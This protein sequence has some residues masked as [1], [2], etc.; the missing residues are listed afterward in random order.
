M[1]LIKKY[2]NRDYNGRIA[3][4]LLLFS[5][6]NFVL[7]VGKFVIAIFTTPFFV[8]SGIINLCNAVSKLVLYSSMK[9][10]KPDLKKASL[11]ISSVMILAS[12]QYIIYMLRTLIFNTKSM[13]YNLSLGCIIA[14]VGFL[15]LGLAIKAILSEKGKG[16]FY[17]I[18]KTM[19]FFSAITAI[20]LTQVAILSFSDSSDNTFLNAMTGSMVGLV[21]LL[22]WIIM[23]IIP[24]FSPIDNSVIQPVDTFISIEKKYLLKSRIFGNYYLSSEDFNEKPVYRIKKEKANY[25]SG[26][27]IFS[28]IT[29]ILLSEILIFVYILLAGIYYL[30][31]L[32]IVGKAK[33][34]IFSESIGI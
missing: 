24:Y 33:K 16:S 29:V 31:T 25:F 10:G 3:V 6:F 20:V 9:K 4:N 30:R 8:V 22:T 19:S 26:L 28:K 15:E 17:R 11:I 5:I 18:Q 23:I 12:I 21:M 7:A 14:L 13:T 32:F 1:S 27:N 2:F 34:L